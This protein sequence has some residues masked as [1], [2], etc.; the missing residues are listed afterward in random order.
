MLNQLAFSFRRPFNCS[1]HIRAKLRSSNHKC[2]F[3]IL[4]SVSLSVSVSVCISPTHPLAH[5]HT[6]TRSLTHT[7]THIHKHTSRAFNLIISHPIRVSSSLHNAFIAWTVI[8]RML[9]FSEINEV[10]LCYFH[11]Y[12]KQPVTKNCHAYSSVEPGNVVLFCDP[13]R[14]ICLVECRLTRQRNMSIS[15]KLH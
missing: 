1:D 12:F 11:S 13:T 5:T 4:V 2:I 15:Y 8:R 3:V 6:H 10:R 7:Q 9:L 14:V